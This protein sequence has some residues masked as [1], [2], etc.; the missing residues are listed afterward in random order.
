MR[1]T[2]SRLVVARLVIGL[3]VVAACDRDP[4]F[5]FEKK[6]IAEVRHQGFR[7]DIP[8]ER[9]GNASF[10]KAA[11]TR[12]G[13]YL[14]TAGSGFRVW[15]ARTG[16]LLRHIPGTLDGNDPLVIDGTH[17]VLL[18]RRGNVAPHLPEANGLGFWDLRDGSL[19]GMIP[20]TFQERATPIG[21]TAS[22][23]AVVLREGAFET[24]ALDGS[25]RRLVIHPPDDFGERWS[26]CMTGMFATY[27]DKLCWELSPSGRWLAVAGVHRDSTRESSH[28]FLIDLE[29]GALSRIVLPDS[30]RDNR[31]AAFA[32]SSDERT[33]AV[34]LARGLWFWTRDGQ[35]GPFTRGQHQRNPYLGAMAFTAGDTRV[36]TL[37]DQLQVSA[38]DAAT[39]ALVGRVAP[40]FED[41]EGTLRV[42]ADGSRAVTYR[43]LSDILVVIDGATGKQRGYVCPYFC[44]RFHNPVDVPY[45]VSPDGRRVAAS[46][47][48]GT[49]IFDVDA[50]TLIVPLED[51]TMPPRRPRS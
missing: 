38:F 42:S 23:M 9:R 21:T 10:Y 3:L 41:W 50:D 15:D 44:N 47:R 22:G 37:G 16:A 48:L 30:L 2:A 46:H 43:F 5:M 28:F 7:Q 19:R 17:E 36:V 20:E 31:L 18:A 39:G 49:G 4:K 25:G 12:D 34:G 40:P 1:Q 24:W 14:V 13:K 27:N 8:D 11:F 32:F 6:P 26:R 45:A 35:P 29:S 51:P 33:I